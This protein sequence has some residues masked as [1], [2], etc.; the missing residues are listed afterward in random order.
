[1]RNHLK[2]KIINSLLIITSLLGYLEWGTDNRS[3][4]FEAEYEILLKILKDPVSVFHPFTLLPMIG[5]LLLLVT[6]FQKKPNK[7][8]T[9]IGMSGLA[10]LLVFMFFIGVLGLNFKIILSTIPF[11]A[12]M[13]IA[14]RHYRKLSYSK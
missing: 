13:I 1:M 2:S 8:L 4:L 10:V 12:V 3:F 14:V 6:L 7:S 5:Q 11:I 9:Y